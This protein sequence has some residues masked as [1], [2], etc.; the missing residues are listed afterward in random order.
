MQPKN[1]ESS[2]IL[3]GDCAPILER[4]E[5]EEITA[6]GSKVLSMP[7]THAGAPQFHSTVEVVAS[8][9][10]WPK[11]WEYLRKTDSAEFH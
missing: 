5:A 8:F 9:V 3:I 1:M 2:P 6:L 11:L 10:N 4:M 7:S